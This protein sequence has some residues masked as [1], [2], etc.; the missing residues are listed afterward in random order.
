[1]KLLKKL[2]IILLCITVLVI[3]VFLLGRYGWKL[4]GFKVCEPAGME[5][6]NVE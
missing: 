3:T 5:Q 4:G 2:L 6:I 1:M